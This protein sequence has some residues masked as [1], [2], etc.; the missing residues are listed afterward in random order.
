MKLRE[1]TGLI[2]FILSPARP[3]GPEVLLRSGS[4]QIYEWGVETLLPGPP[5]FPLQ[6]AAYLGKPQSS[7]GE[8]C[9]IEKTT[10][11]LEGT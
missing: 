3:S 6:L 7:V 9:V 1:F 8:V 5:E 2:A 11:G 10:Q 4:A